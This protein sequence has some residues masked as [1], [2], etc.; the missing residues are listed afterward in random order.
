MFTLNSKAGKL[1]FLSFVSFVLDGPFCL[2]VCFCCCF[3]F[4]RVKSIL[5][6]FVYNYLSIYLTIIPRVSV[7]YEMVDS[8]R[9]AYPAGGTPLYQ[10]YRYVPPGRVWY[11]RLPRTQTSLFDVRAKEGG[12]ESSVPFPWSLAVHHQS[13]AFRARL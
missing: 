13:L 3:F 12:K 4:S 8:Q 1:H 7:G 10:L 6:P 11:L 5:R 9:G 2:F